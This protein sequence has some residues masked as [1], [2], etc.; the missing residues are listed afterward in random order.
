MAEP[1]SEA[2][3]AAIAALWRDAQPRALERVEVLEAAVAALAAGAIG[4]ALA[5]EATREA[6]KLAGALGTFGMPAGTTHARAI[7]L[8]LGGDAAPADAPELAE[9]VA[10]LRAIVEGGPDRG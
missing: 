7:E 6:H 1:D 3:D 5:E 2:L 9:G 4:G 8:R 10:A